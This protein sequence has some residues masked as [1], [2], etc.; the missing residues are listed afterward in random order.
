MIDGQNFFHQPVKNDM[1]ICNNIRKMTIGQGDDYTTGSLLD[2]PYFKENYKLIAIDLSKQQALDADPKAI[3]QS[4]FT[5]NLQSVTKIMGK[6]AIGAISC[7][8]PLPP[9]NNVEKQ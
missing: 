8:Y 1:R 6:T 9:L 2:H 3:Q 5:G 4:N 7:F